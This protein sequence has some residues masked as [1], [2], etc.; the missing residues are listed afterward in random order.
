M[1]LEDLKNFRHSLKFKI[2]AIILLL[3]AL[4]LA[5]VLGITLNVSLKENT[6]QWEIKEQEM[7]LN[8]VVQS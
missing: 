4:M 8:K 5:A 7:I 2:T 1:K 3:E 6:K